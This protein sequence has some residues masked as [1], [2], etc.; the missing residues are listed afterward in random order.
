[1][2]LQ[3]R[4]PGGFV[5]VLWPAGVMLLVSSE[6]L[7]VVNLG[8]LFNRPFVSG[9][10]CVSTSPCACDPH[11]PRNKGCVTFVVGR[12]RSDL[13]G[14]GSDYAGGLTDR[15]LWIP[16][17][18]CIGL[19]PST[20]KWGRRRRLDCLGRSRGETR[21]GGLSLQAACRD[22]PSLSCFLLI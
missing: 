6:L 12:V 10:M 7:L 17:V 18:F 11:A 19:P 1:M 3:Q 9:G 13:V 2:V 21:P 5:F 8:W 4:L 20:T 14:V 22:A 15:R 16:F